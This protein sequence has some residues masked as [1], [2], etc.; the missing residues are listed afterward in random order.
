MPIKK[1]SVKKI[2]LDSS[3]YRL[4]RN[5]GLVITVRKGV[6]AGI[7][8]VNKKPEKTRLSSVIFDME[9]GYTNQDWFRRKYPHLA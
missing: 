1:F 2:K 9:Y 5:D 6:K 7:W 3:H 4:E 8:W